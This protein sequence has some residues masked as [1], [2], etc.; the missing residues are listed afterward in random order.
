M[1]KTIL[2]KYAKLIAAEGGNVQKGQDVII[3]ASVEQPEFAKMVAEECYRLGA[4]AVNLEWSYQPMTKLHYKACTLTTLSKLEDYQIAKWKYRVEKLPVMIYLESDDPDGL[5]GINQVKM[6]KA[7]QAIYKVIKPFREEME[8]KY[9][10]C[11]AGV[12]G[13]AWAKKVFPGESR[14]RAMEKLWEKILVTARVTEDGDPV[15]EWENHNA[16][17]A[18]RC[19]YLNNLGIETLEYR[20]S[21]GTDLRVGMIEDALFMGGAESALGSGI[22]FNPNI[23][24]E[25]VFISPMKGVA[26]GI[27]YSSKPLSYRGELIE[28]FSIRFEGGKAVEVKAERNEELLKEMISMDEGAAYLG[29]CALVPFESPVNQADVL[30][31][32]TLFD[33]NAVCHLAMGHGFTNVIKDFDKYTLAECYQKGI[34]DSMIHVDFM[35][36]TRDLSIVGITRDGR[37]VQIF[38]NGTWAF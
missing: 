28:N 7:S 2:R 19:E 5:K 30:F 4:R 24:T 23:P 17:L 26:E 1:K 16:D 18:A 37:R 8:N 20:S 36:G 29:E 6:S 9:Q 12:P 21:N 15:Q 27:V 31:Y 25:E 13:A 10:W 34:N 14:S 33:E 3:Y 32:N 38:E 35:I 22:V 11:I